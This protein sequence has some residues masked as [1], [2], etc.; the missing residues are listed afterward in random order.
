MAETLPAQVSTFKVIGRLVKS[1]ADSG[2]ADAE[3]DVVPIPGATIIFTPAVSPPIIRIPTASPPVTMFLESITA[4]TDVDGYLKI[5]ADSVRG[6]TLMYGS[7]PDI[8]PNGWTW[9]VSISVGGNFPTRSFS[10]AGS[11]GAV[12]DLATLIPVSSSPGVEVAA[13]QAAVNQVTSVKSEAVIARDSATAA[14][15]AAATY[16]DQAEAASTA[17]TASKNAAAAS[18]TSAA[19]SRDLADASKTAAVAAKDAA[20]AASSDALASKN[21]AASSATTAASDRGLATSAKDAAVSARDAAIVARDTAAEYTSTASSSA[22]AATSARDASIA[23]K[24]TAVTARDEV[25]ALVEDFET[26][27][28]SSGPSTVVYALS[29]VNAIRPAVSGTVIWYVTTGVIPV[30]AGPMDPIIT[31]AVT[32]TTPAAPAGTLYDWK[33]SSLVGSNG[34]IL[35]DDS[36]VA[37]WPAALGGFAFAAGA[38]S[39][40]PKMATVGGRKALL[41]D[42]VDDYMVAAFGQLAQPFAF[43]LI[44]QRVGAIDLPASLRFF[45][46]NGTVTPWRASM[47][48]GAD[49]SLERMF[50]GTNANLTSVTSTT[51]R[52]LFSGVFSGATSVGRRNGTANTVSPGTEGLDGAR[53]GG[54]AVPTFSNLAVERVIIGTFN[55]ATIN[56]WRQQSAVASF[57]AL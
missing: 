7:D 55:D 25:V 49:S 27:G 33:L 51:D 31:V 57:Y 52:G 13:W 43:I 36:P 9:G 40:Q 26:G 17:A 28:G 39:A 6:V 21:A 48:K 38:G 5:A 10:I 41:F 15:V 30:N 32:D 12:L 19:S 56:A 4:T 8:M 34:L 54:S 3:P 50:A 44:G 45:G 47:L 42:G 35:P 24:N 23:A 14:S 16:R 18:V 11:E 37:S 29:D 22:T 46:S 53:L 1:I 2:D 20:V